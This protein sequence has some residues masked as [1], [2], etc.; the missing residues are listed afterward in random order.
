MVHILLSTRA[1]VRIGAA[2]SVEKSARQQ[3]SRIVSTLKDIR[4]LKRSVVSVRKFIKED[5]G[6]MPWL[7]GNLGKRRRVQ[8]EGISKRKSVDYSTSIWYE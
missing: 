1:R 8:A 6:G 2:V 5:G 7:E 4:Q 3:H